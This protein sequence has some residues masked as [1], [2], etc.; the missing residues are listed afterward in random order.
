[1]QLNQIVAHW[2]VFEVLTTPANQLLGA[3]PE[4]K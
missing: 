4:M 1:M 2:I 3:N